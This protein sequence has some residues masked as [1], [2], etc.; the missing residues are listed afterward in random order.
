MRSK[1]S[2][3]PRDDESS[4]TCHYAETFKPGDSFVIP[5]GLKCTWY[6]PET[7]RTYKIILTTETAE[8]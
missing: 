7:T 3:K 8:T 1:W 6:V 2:A 4:L 5:K